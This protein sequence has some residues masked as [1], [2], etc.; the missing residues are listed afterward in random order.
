MQARDVRP[1][2]GRQANADVQQRRLSATEPE[3]DYQ[4]RDVRTSWSCGCRISHHRRRGRCAGRRTRSGGRG[5]PS[6]GGDQPRR[7]AV[8]QFAPTPAAPW[9][10]RSLTQAGL[11]EGRADGAAG[12]AGAGARRPRWRLWW[13]RARAGHAAGGRSPASEGRQRQLPHSLVT[14]RSSGAVRRRPVRI[15]GHPRQGAE[16]RAVRRCRS[17]PDHRQR[18]QHVRVNSERLAQRRWPARGSDR[19]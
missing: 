10:Q 1:N 14:R 4:G 15:C 16:G 7:Q 11:V 18:R 8:V 2:S 3:A 5:Q 17:Q 6:I 9:R 12:A 19:S 13:R